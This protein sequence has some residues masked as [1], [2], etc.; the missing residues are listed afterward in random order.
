MV[1][2]TLN[3]IKINILEQEDTPY[4]VIVLAVDTIKRLRL[5]P[6]VIFTCFRLCKQFN[7]YDYVSRLIHPLTRLLDKNSN[8][9]VRE[10][11]LKV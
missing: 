9:E 4:Q 2:L 7:L 5:E 11:V 3:A 6:S 8:P 1:T 10:H